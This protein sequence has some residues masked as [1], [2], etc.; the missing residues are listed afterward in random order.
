MPFAN[1]GNLLTA[2]KPANKRKQKNAP[3]INATT[4]LFVKLL[5][6]LYCPHAPN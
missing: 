3:L 2:S 6:T 1:T 4:V 5:A